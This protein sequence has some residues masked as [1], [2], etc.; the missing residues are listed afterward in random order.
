MACTLLYERDPVQDY[1]N[2]EV[3]RVM[4]VNE[5]Q[6]LDNDGATR[7]NCRIFPWVI[8]TLIH[9]TFCFAIL[10]MR[11]RGLFAWLIATLVKRQLNP[12]QREVHPF[13][14]VVSC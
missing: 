6:Q 5:E 9:C 2:L 11:I 7:C 1:V 3:M 14:H 13:Y 8:P 10:R 4:Q 12:L